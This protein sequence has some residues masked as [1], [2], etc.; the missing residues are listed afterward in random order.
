MNGQRKEKIITSRM[1]DNERIERLE[2]KF[3]Q[4][5]ERKYKMGQTE[6]CY[7]SERNGFFSLSLH[8][9]LLFFFLE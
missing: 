7:F 4:E 8:F 1:N 5:Q 6:K 3:I 2:M 9:F